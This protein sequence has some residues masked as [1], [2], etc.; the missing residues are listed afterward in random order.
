MIAG[1]RASV[2]YL[3][4][5][6]ERQFRCRFQDDARRDKTKRMIAGVPIGRKSHAFCYRL[7]NRELSAGSARSCDDTPG[8]RVPSEGRTSFCSPSLGELRIRVV[9]SAIR[10]VLH[11][12]KEVVTDQKRPSIAPTVIRFP[13]DGRCK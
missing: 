1:V 10:A 12:D 3:I 13:L 11:R 9:A 5:P 8:K 2:A 4:G 7:L 6:V